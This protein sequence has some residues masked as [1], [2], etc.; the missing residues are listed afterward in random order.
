MTDL[1]AELRIPVL[2]IR[3]QTKE[4]GLADRISKERFSNKDIEELRIINNKTTVR[5]LA[6]YKS[7]DSQALLKWLNN[8]FTLH[9]SN[10]DNYIDKTLII[11]F[12]K[13]N[14]KLEIKQQISIGE[15]IN[16]GIKQGTDP[17][18]DKTFI[19]DALNVCRGFSQRKGD[20]KL[21]Y[22]LSLVK[23]IL[24]RKGHFVSIFDANVRNKLKD[25]NSDEICHFD[26][27]RSLA[28]DYFCMSTGG[29]KL[30]ILF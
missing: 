17:V 14:P 26:N 19:V 23:E 9:I 28:S 8:E 3:D 22:L 5:K 29:L 2:E 20:L 18:K 12:L 6:E 24:N 4:L 16:G 11:R 27:L 25:E 30:M 21:K 10:E 1:S 15:N 7:I 13:E